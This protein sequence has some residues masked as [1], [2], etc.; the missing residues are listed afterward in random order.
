MRPNLF[1]LGPVP[2][3]SFGLMVLIGFG[4]ALYYAL[5]TVRR[6]AKNSKTPPVIT[7]DHV[8]DW[9]ITSLFVCVIGARIMYVLLDWHEFKNNPIDVV[10]VWTGGISIHGAIISGSLYMWWYCRRHKLPFLAF[11]DIIA[12][13]FALGYAIGRIGCF[14]NGCCYGYACDLP[15]ATKFLRDGHSDLWTKPSHPTQLYAT[16]MNLIWFGI[17]DR[18]I[19]RP[20]RDGQ[21]FLT[22]L[23]LY[24]VY[25]FIDEQFRKGAT[26]DI[27]VAGFTH[28]QVFSMVVLPIVLAF[29]WRLIKS[30]VAKAAEA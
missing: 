30:P 9:A 28:A 4:L 20:H 18:L 5:S 29:L 27:F 6:Q 15:W 1:Q 14:L 13:S 19:R 11:A 16:G 7:P 3:R 2:I 26:A 8:F 25:R 22:Y 23:A 17:L 21:I 12:T 10:K 24:C